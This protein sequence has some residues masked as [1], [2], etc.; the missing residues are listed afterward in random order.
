M[1]IKSINDDTSVL[2]LENE[3]NFTTEATLLNLISDTAQSNVNILILDFSNV[4]HFNSDG[5]ASLVKGCIIAR[6]SN[7]T[8][9]SFGLSERYQGIFQLTGLVNNILP[10]K[11]GQN[12]TRFRSDNEYKQLEEMNES[13]G[14]QDSKGWSTLNSKLTVSDHRPNAININVNNRRV[15]GPLQGF[16][17]LWEKEYKL[18]ITNSPISFKELMSKFRSSFITLQPKQNVFYPSS[19]GIEAGETVLIDSSTPGGVVSTGVHILYAD[20]VSFSFIT[21]Q[22]HPEAGWI[23]FSANEND[24]KIEIKIRSLASASDPF[25]ELAFRIAGSNFQETIWKTVLVNMAKSINVDD[26]VIITKTKID[27][28]LHWK[29]IQNLWFNA[30]LRSLPY[31]V[32]YY[33]KKLINK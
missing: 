15:L 19:K 24:E 16:G 26:T 5:D 10:I 25:F 29:A 8:L 2:I 23:T 4:D 6:N 17:P 32:P 22:G 9:Y 7:I 27:N 30:Q 12:S 21:P 33:F 1:Q 18:Q 13:K 28:K 11:A 31:N 14:I 3:L 20:D